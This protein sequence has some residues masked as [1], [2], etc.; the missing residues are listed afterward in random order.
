MVVLAEVQE[1]LRDDDVVLTVNVDIMMPRTGGYNARPYSSKLQLYEPPRPS[2][3]KALW[4]WW[5]RVVLSGVYGGQKDYDELDKEASEILGGTQNQS[6]F[7]LIIDIDDYEQMLERI[8]C[9]VKR[10][11]Q[12]LLDVIKKIAEKY[13]SCKELKDMATLKLKLLPILID[14]TNKGTSKN[15]RQ[16]IKKEFG[17][18][19]EF[20]GNNAKIRIDSS[21]KLLKLVESLGID[22]DKETVELYDKIVKLTKIPRIS[23]LKQ[24][25][26]ED[27]EDDSFRF[28]SIQNT[29]C[30]ISE[31]NRR[32]LKRMVEDIAYMAAAP[33]RINA[34]IIVIRNK[35]K[36]LGSEKLELAIASLLLSLLL[37]GLGSMSR[38]GFGSLALKDVKPGSKYRNF[39]MET[40]NK[41]NKILDASDENTLEQRLI[42]Y[43]RFVV[44]LARKV[45]GNRVSN[46]PSK[47]LKIPRVPALM[48]G[49]DYFRLKVFGYNEGHDITDDIDILEIIGKAT[50]KVQWRREY[51]VSKKIPRKEFHTWILGLPRSAGKELKGYLVNGDRGRRTSAITFKLFENV[52]G[53]K[54]VI[55]YGFLSRDWPIDKLIYTNDLKG[56]KVTELP[57]MMPSLK[58]TIMPRGP[59]EEY[60]KFVFDAAFKFTTKILERKLKVSRS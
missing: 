20:S 21:E 33:N 18:K 27:S 26:K 5:L 46:S 58:D 14:F 30:K 55:V 6:L 34:R 44:D 8:R 59:S 11:E 60:L 19:P 38:R 15:L 56:K 10:F 54:Y 7:S 35:N 42:E 16:I 53:R 32:F 24:P 25:R 49:T 9:R 45:L 50:L 17:L 37:G 12:L 28:N 22:F 39:L 1:A 48:P 4:R 2:E 57:I 31:S 52:Q 41:V 43:T 29:D 40:V 47:D 3:I 13:N 23:L 51:G 36:K